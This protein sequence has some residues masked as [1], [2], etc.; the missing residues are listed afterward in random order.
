[1]YL[2][3]VELDIYNRKKIRDLRDLNSYHGFVESCFPEEIDKEI[4]TRKLWRID[5]ISGKKYLLILSQTRPNL[6]RLEKYGIKDSGE[7]KLYDAF[8]GKL[9]NGMKA[10]FRIKLNTV[11]SKANGQKTRR[12][13]ILPVKNENLGKFFL[14]R[15]EKN[16]F[17]VEDN[18]FSISDIGSLDFK[19][20]DNKVYQLSSATYEGVLTI[21]DINQFKKA[22][23]NGIGRKKAY[24][25]GLLTVIPYDR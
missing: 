17:I 3:R 12:G 11:F 22:L 2:S 1:M 24:G 23:I 10:R 5:N 13:R 8:I 18:E 20:E 6:E 4:R 19:R 25:F 9:E 15:A 14:E 21:K 16:G 7:S